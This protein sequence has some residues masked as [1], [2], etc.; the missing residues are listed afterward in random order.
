MAYS[1]L[2]NLDTDS[3]QVVDGNGKIVDVPYRNYVTEKAGTYY[4]NAGGEM[5]V[6]VELRAETFYFWADNQL[7]A[8]KK[9]SKDNA[10]GN[11]GYYLL[12][13]FSQVN[14]RVTHKSGGSDKLYM[15][16]QYEWDLWARKPGEN[17]TLFASQG[18]KTYPN[19]EDGVYSINGLKIT[20]I[21]IVDNATLV[22][23]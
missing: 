23:S 22:P 15:L 13:L 10:I 14:V 9:I 8:L 2:M 20:K 21:N 18:T 19:V 12:N 3:I 4:L 5:G 16:K 11:Q 1:S 17:I 7:T 6:P